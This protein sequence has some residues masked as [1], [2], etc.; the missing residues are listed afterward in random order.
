MRSIPTELSPNQFGEL[1]DDDYLGDEDPENNVFLSDMMEHAQAQIEDPAAAAA[2]VPFTLEGAYEYI[3]RVRWMQTHDPQTDYMERELRNEAVKRLAIGM[4]FPPEFLLGMSDANHWTAR[5]V[6]Y[7]MWR[8]YGSPVAERF[9]DDLS[10]AYLRPALEEAGYTGWENVVVA[11]DDSQVVIPPD[12]TED[13]LKAHAAGI[14]NEEAAREALGWNDDAK[15]VGD[16]LDQ[17]L[18]I[19]LRQPELLDGAEGLQLP[20]RGPVAEMNGNSPED[21]PPNPNGGREVSRQEARTA[22][23]LGAASL[24]LMRCRELAGVRIRHKCPDCAEGHP[25]TLVASVMGSVEDP[26]KLVRGGTDSFRSWLQEQDFDPS[27]AASLC[28][29]LEILAA[30]TLSEPR[31]PDLPSGF[32]AAVLKAEEVSLAL[33]H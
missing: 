1:A 20:R 19:K 22:S 7:D 6:V 28:Q 10:D 24:S 15:M 30:R 9:G 21:G 26:L 11:F 14:I 4:D 12:R 5:Q 16:E 32:V 23:I 29:Q 3:D 33:E 31:C 13:A 17:F 25:L 8:S 27:Q 18:A 2:K